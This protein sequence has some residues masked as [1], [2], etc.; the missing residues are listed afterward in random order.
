[1]HQVKAILFDLDGVLVN[2]RVLHY[3]TFRDALEEVCPGSNLTW[4][5]HEKT[6]DGLSTKRKLD[7]LVETNKITKEQSQRIFEIKQ[8]LTEERLPLVIKPRES[9]KLLLVTLNNQGFRLFCCS[10]SVRKT[11][12]TT[13]KLL[14]IL[15]FFEAT[16]SN[17]DV[18]R[19][20]PSPEMYEKAMKEAFIS[21]SDC[22]I[23]E[24]SEV[25]KQAAYATGAH[26]LEV[27]DAEDVT[28]TLLR[29][30]LYSIEK[31]GEVYPRLLPTKPTTFHIVI[32]MAGEGSRFRDAGY[33][34]PK[35]FIEVGGKPM[36]QWVI[37]NMIPK[38]LPTDSY[39][40]K[41][42]LIVRSSH[43]KGNNLDRLFWDTPSN[44]SY[45]YH[46]T[47]GL[48][49]GAACSVLLAEN[50]INTNEPLLIINSDQFLEWKPDSFYKCLLNPA[51]DGII[52]TFY[53]PNPYD[54]KWS[55]A[56]TNSDELVTEVQEKKWIS[57]YATV[58][59]YG[60][61]RGSDFVRYAK[62]M[63]QKNIRVKNEFY[64]CPVYNES[65]GDGQHVRVKLCSGMWGLGVPEDLETFRK[66]Y[67]KEPT[68]G[69][70]L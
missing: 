3:E 6:F 18:E 59:L 36:I 16:Y 60:W 48:T 38:D 31:R 32:P 35:P 24:D 58:G 46:T 34:I 47:N 15:P 61:K 7:L 5:E 9:L 19:P 21:P 26:V 13:L 29:E 68:D 62:Q 25:G 49:E 67:L 55:Y 10:N 20:K 50:E 40:V 30:T 28:L 43:I 17:E 70:N 2:S 8:R 4:A 54:V 27:E 52:L 23:V 11:L 14:E 42:H 56:K 39:K 69:K 33:T 22:L 41:F 65:I 1:M 64:V 57:P 12:D 53:Q 66:E 44:V 37:E 45:T 51:Y 63:I